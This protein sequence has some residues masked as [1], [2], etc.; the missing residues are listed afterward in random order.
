MPYR[1]MMR[2]RA[3]SGK[4]W[5]AETADREYRRGDKVIYVPS[6]KLVYKTLRGA[7][8]RLWVEVLETIKHRNKP[9][10]IKAMLRVHCMQAQPG[11]VIVE[12]ATDNDEI[13]H[14]IEEV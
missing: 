1:V 13:E 9:D 6:K 7:R 14:W 8:Q 11:A 5:Q 10:L 3:Q 12:N 4:P 2:S